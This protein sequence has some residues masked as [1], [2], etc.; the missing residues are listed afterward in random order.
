MWEL[1]VI[2]LL[3]VASVGLFRWLGGFGAAG[4]AVRSWGRAHSTTRVP[5]GSSS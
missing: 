4:D 1:I 5:S 3:Y 2:L